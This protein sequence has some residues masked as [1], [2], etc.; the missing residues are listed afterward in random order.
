LKEYE[1]GALMFEKSM[2]YIPR[3]E[4]NRSRRSN[5]FRVLCLCHLALAQLDRAQEF[6]D[7]AEKVHP[8]E[9]NII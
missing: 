8:D 9:V 5:C 6:I 1:I 7:Q 2:L 3:D 4:E